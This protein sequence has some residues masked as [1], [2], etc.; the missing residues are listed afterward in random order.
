[1]E[2][3]RVLKKIFDD[4]TLWQ[5]MYHGTQM[6]H[7]ALDDALY[8]LS[9]NPSVELTYKVD[10]LIEQAYDRGLFPR[11]IAQR[12]HI[13]MA[14]K[15]LRMRFNPHAKGYPLYDPM[16]IRKRLEYAMRAFEADM[17]PNTRNNLWVVLKEACIVDLITEE[18]KNEFIDDTIAYAEGM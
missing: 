18:S 5:R 3:E 6:V 16:E 4:E 10:M 1:M 8:N 2:V 14:L 7:L 17:N 15:R 12:A 9:Q 13:D 11:E